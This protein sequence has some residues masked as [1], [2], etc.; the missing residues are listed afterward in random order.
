[1]QGRLVRLLSVN[2]LDLSQRLLQRYNWK[3]KQRPRPRRKG[4]E[5]KYVTTPFSLSHPP[6]ILSQEGEENR[7]TSREHAIF[8]VERRF[9]AKVQ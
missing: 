5:Y 4:V 7:L 9:D 2:Y 1:M 8:V 3:W 6:Y